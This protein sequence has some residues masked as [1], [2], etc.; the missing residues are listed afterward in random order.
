MIYDFITNVFTVEN[1]RASVEHFPGLCIVFACWIL[2]LVWRIWRFTIYPLIYPNYPKELP[3]W[4]PSE[5][6][7]LTQFDIFFNSQSSSWYV[8]RYDYRKCDH[9]SYWA[10]GHAKSFFLNSQELMTQA[11]YFNL[12]TIINSHTDI[13]F[14]LYFGN[15]REPFSVTVAGQQLYILTSSDD[16]TAVFKDTVSFSFEGFIKDIMGQN[17]VTKEGI[18]KM[19]QDID[20]TKATVNNLLHKPLGRLARDLHLHQLSPG[21]LL[22]DTSRAFV[23]YFENAD[24]ILIKKDCRNVQPV[25]DA[26]AVRV[27]L[28]DWTADMLTMAG[29]EA[30]WGKLLKKIEPNMVEVFM[31]FDLLT[32]QMLYQYP[33]FLCGKMRAARNKMVEAFE[34][35]YR[36]PR[37]ERSDTLWWTHAF[38]D[39]IRALNFS[40]RDF[41]III[42]T[43]YWG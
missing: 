4:V 9:R 1:L 27:Q 22:N 36:A 41:G 6:F 18:H 14:R 23:K 34:K 5:L 32:W 31:E 3:Y 37:S 8:I 2:L 7:H 38:E 25:P 26:K 13:L 35:Y 43:I 17:G 12:R 40:E 30:Y 33:E 21:Q 10:I 20:P 11:R 24:L 16:V 15:K 28:F 39:E 19:F 42:A 29:Q